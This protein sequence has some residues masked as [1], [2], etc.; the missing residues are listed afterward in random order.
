MQQYNIIKLDETDSTNAYAH[1]FSASFEDRTVVSA[2]K[3]TAGRG[4][5]NRKWL[6]GNSSNV[7]M[8]FVLKPSD[9]GDYPYSNLTQYLSVIVCRVLENCYDMQPS[10]KWPNDI[11]VSGA[12]IAGILAETSVKD[13]KIDCI[14]L[15]IGINVNLE[16]EIIDKID[17]KA[18]SMAVLKHRSFESDEIRDKICSAFFED[19]DKFI[20]KGFSYIKEEYVKRCGF[21]GGRIKIREQNK[22]FWA[23]SVDDDGL[24]AVKDDFGI[25][26]KIITG[27]VLCAFVQ[28]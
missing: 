7:Y 11:L 26:S 1:E 13:G 5:Y 22:E 3:Q 2:A 6:A 25:E 27:D 19:Y 16:K 20:Q 17:Q 18:V 28:K 15:G 9:T 14:A 12:K 8:T 10:I 23:Q 24:L 21:L 4:R